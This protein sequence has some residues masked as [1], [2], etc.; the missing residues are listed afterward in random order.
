MDVFYY[1]SLFKEKRNA[2]KEIICL[3]QYPK[4]TLLGSAMILSAL[5]GRVYRLNL[6]IEYVTAHGYLSLYTGEMLENLNFPLWTR[7]SGT[8]ILVGYLL[9]LYSFPKRKTFI[10]ISGVFLFSLFFESLMG[11]RAGFISGILAI[12]YFYIRFYKVMLKIKYIIIVFSIIIIFSIWISFKRQGINTYSILTDTLIEFIH[13][14]SVSIM[15]PF[16]VI[17]EFGRFKNHPYPFIFQPIFKWGYDIFYHGAPFS[18]TVLE[19]YNDMA[20]IV[21][22]SMDPFVYNTKGLSVG[23]AVLGEMYDC[24][25]FFGV[26]FWSAFLAVFIKA[27]EKNILL[28]NSYIPFLWFVINGIILAPRAQMFGFVYQLWYVFCGFILIYFINFIF[29]P[30][31]MNINYKNIHTL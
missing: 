24:G 18:K 12:L 30:K 25:G 28:K 31:K 14:Q 2:V 5:A 21:G 8:I 15:I 11:G 27:V 19:K 4:V 9:F 16:E 3:Q 29:Y 23:S 17:E 6:Q 20:A 26:I 7:G 13:G 1:F 22:H 10:K